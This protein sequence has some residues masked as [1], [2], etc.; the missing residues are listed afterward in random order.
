MA[1]STWL[2]LLEWGTPGKISRNLFIVFVF[3]T[4]L[5]FDCFSVLFNVVCTACLVSI[6]VTG[7]EGRLCYHV[8]PEWNLFDFQ[9]N[10]YLK[11]T[12][13][14]LWLAPAQIALILHKNLI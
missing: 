5:G 2:G 14:E 1:N 10:S 9:I 8:W 3:C 11:S 7:F 6:A 4:L 12:I 13:L